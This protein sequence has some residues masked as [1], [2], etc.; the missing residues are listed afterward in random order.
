MEAT[1]SLPR[2]QNLATGRQASLAGQSNQNIT[3]SNLCVLI[4]LVNCFWIISIGE[5]HAFIIS[6]M[7]SSVYHLWMKWS[8]WRTILCR[9]NFQLKV[10]RLFAKLPQIPLDASVE[11]IKR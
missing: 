2:N 3:Q 6:V 5:P 7:V 10:R 1:D 9:G 8:Q 4:L 11:L